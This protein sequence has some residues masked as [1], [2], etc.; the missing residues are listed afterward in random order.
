MKS[1]YLSN[2]ES[3][4]TVDQASIYHSILNVISDGVWVSDREG[5]VKFLNQTWLNFTGRTI[6]EELSHQWNG[7]DIHPDDRDSCL[8]TYLTKF[9][10]SE[11]FDHVF[12]LMRQDGEYRWIHEFVKPYY[13]KDKRHTGFVGTCIDITDS[14]EAIFFANR[15]LREKNKDLEQFVY[16]ASHDLKEPLRMIDSF[17]ELIQSRFN[18]GLPEKAQEYVNCMQTSA[19]RMKTL[20]DDLLTYSRISS[21]IKPFIETDL[22]QVIDEVII[23]LDLYIKEYNAKIDIESLPVIEADASEIKQLCFN[24]LINGLKYHRKDESPKIKVTCKTVSVSDPARSQIEPVNMIELVF[25]DNGIGFNEKYKDRIFE[26]FQR[27]HGRTEYEG[28]GIGLAICR[29][30][31]ELHHGTIRASS[32]EGKGSEFIVQLPLNQ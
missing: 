24:I 15:K 23:D 32:K 7:E 13:G 16:I 12:R 21:H 19:S 14:K 9:K 25:K 31:I 17:G 29:K 30:I 4:E 27:L 10:S 2:T 6:E 22:N 8:Y 28:T 5:Q 18:E 11:P 1:L 20:I 3:G 26:P